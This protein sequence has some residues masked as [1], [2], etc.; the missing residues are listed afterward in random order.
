[1][2]DKDSK[3]RFVKG[4]ILG[5]RF[6]KGQVSANKGRNYKCKSYNLTE[7]GR[8]QKIKN[9][10]TGMLGKKQSDKFIQ[11]M[12][13]IHTGKII[14]KA[15][16]EQMSKSHKEKGLSPPKYLWFKKGHLPSNETREKLRLIRQ[17][18]ILEDGGIVQIGKDEKQILD[19][20]ETYLEVP[21]FRQ[22]RTNG[23]FLDGYSPHLN[24][25]FEVDEPFHLNQIDKDIERENIIKQELN[26][27]FVRIPTNKLGL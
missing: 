5:N 13:E 17:E 20:I 16:R 15:Q 12:K 14:S 22:V 1:M 7:D 3:G 24:T 11:K 4:H 25:V 21:I 8:L 27:Q 2:T 6:T 26:C 19:Y 10:G 18:Q 9:L 23:Y